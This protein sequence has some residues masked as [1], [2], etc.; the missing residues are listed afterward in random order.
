[1]AHP[2]TQEQTC[3]Q[4]TRVAMVLC[5]L[6]HK[7]WQALGLAL[8]AALRKGGG[9]GGLEPEWPVSLAEVADRDICVRGTFLAYMAYLLRGHKA[10]YQRAP[11]RAAT[12]ARPPPISP[13]DANETAHTPTGT[14]SGRTASAASDSSRTS[15][16]ASTTSFRPGSR[17]SALF[18]RFS[19][20][21]QSQQPPPPPQQ[22]QQ[23]QQQQQTQLQLSA[24]AD[25]QKRDAASDLARTR[26]LTSPLNE[27]P[28]SPA[29]RADD[30][31]ASL[32]VDAYVARRANADP[33][34]AAFY[35]V[36]GAAPVPPRPSAQGG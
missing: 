5:A 25:P 4:L 12:L 27:T 10:C 30:T 15:S 2:W 18:A 32:N 36:G 3:S 35:A 16:S 28:T 31:Q 29:P 11:R 21:R 20:S 24:G 17:I 23:Q 34:N 22:Q 13:L 7:P 6:S 14:V 26:T 9:T 33:D 8:Q 1:M 19:D